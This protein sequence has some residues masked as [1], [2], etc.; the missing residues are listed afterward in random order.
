MGDIVPF[1]QNTSSGNT[2]KTGQGDADR[3]LY[4]L[5]QKGVVFDVDPDIV[6]EAGLIEES[7]LT[8][9]EAREANEELADEDE[10]GEANE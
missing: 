6:E 8:W 1:K 3:L 10:S 9:Q 7:A 4:E 5:S 2:D